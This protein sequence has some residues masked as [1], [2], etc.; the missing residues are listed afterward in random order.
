MTNRILSIVILLCFST[1]LWPET[2][3]QKKRRTRQWPIDIRTETF[4]FDDSSPSDH[5]WQDLR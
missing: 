1:T 4:G 3:D 5:P 2:E